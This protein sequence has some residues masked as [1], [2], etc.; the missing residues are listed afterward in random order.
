MEQSFSPHI[1][2]VLL[3]N[4]IRTSN[5]LRL[6]TPLPTSGLWSLDVEY[7][8]RYHAKNSGGAGHSDLPLHAFSKNMKGGRLWLKPEDNV[9][10]LIWCSVLCAECSCPSTRCH[11]QGSAIFKKLALPTSYIPGCHLMTLAVPVMGYERTGD[12]GTGRLVVR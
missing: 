5:S 2:Q 4:Q 7:G 11:R 10:P 3:R 1:F 8:S 12:F 6:K 9:V